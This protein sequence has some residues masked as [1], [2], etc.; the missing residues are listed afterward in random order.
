MVRCDLHCA[1]G[2][3]LLLCMLGVFSGLVACQEDQPQRTIS[4]EELNPNSETPEPDAGVEEDTPEEEG[5]D[6]NLPQPAALEVFLQP[7][8]AVYAPG[9]KLLP[10]ARVYD[11]FG[12]VMEGQEVVWNVQPSEA[13]TLQEDTGRYLLDAEGQTTFEGCI[14]EVCN[15]ITIL[16]DESAPSVVLTSPEPGAYLLASE[17]P[18]IQVQG[19]VA[20]SHG[21]VLLYVNGNFVE[22]DA[23][24]DFSVELQPRFGINHIEILASDG[25]QDRDTIAGGDVLWAYDFLNPGGERAMFHVKHG[26]QLHLGQNFMD[27]GEP[28]TFEGENE[29]VRTR[30]LAGVLE[31]LLYE[32]DFM[33]QIPNPV[34]DSEVLSLAVSDVRVEKPTIEVRVVDEGLELYIQA[35]DVRVSTQGSFDF[36]GEGL[37]LRGAIYAT[38]SA[39]VHIRLHKSAP[40]SPYETSITSVEIALEEARPQFVDG[41]ANAVFEFA[42]G[43]LQTVLVGLVEE[44]ILNSFIQDLPGVLEEAILSIESSLS[45]QSFDLSTGVGDPIQMDLGVRV[46]SL[47][48]SQDKHVLVAM[49]L[50]VDTQSLPLHADAPGA[51]LALPAGEHQVPFF[52]T[53]RI[54]VGLPLEL[55]NGLLFTIWNAGILNL[56]VASFLPSELSFLIQ[57]V[58]LKSKLPPVMTAPQ[59]DEGGSDLLLT[60]GQLEFAAQFA[61]QRDVYGINISVGVNIGLEEGSLVLTIDPEPQMKIWVVETDADASFFTP[62]NLGNA[63]RA[64]LWPQISGIFEE[65]LAVKL[66]SLELG[67]S[68]G[69]IAPGLSNFTLQVVQESPIQVQDGFV[70]FEGNLEGTKTP[71]Q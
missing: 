6:P 12:E 11:Q 20:D 48:A 43:A 47:K 26:L 61:E 68:V 51:P 4:L 39:F 40:E 59:I 42:E 44:Q 53:R 31:L 16:V 10:E 71:A 1:H 3:A 7:G 18:T 50:E 15:Q 34:V 69:E 56:D 17:H 64:Q 25:L 2:A 46:H 57:E 52:S 14:E 21:D 65:S 70:I 23:S 19:Q 55:L 30:D 32:I 58:E 45:G 63:L 27:D 5:P 60:L 49:D 24:G 9:L 54:Q 22:P 67:S 66:P 62:E 37:D 29:E 41:E 28:L 38:L 8:R 13:A 36:E 35:S 33:G